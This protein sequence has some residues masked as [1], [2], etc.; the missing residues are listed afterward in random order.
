MVHASQ[1]G[2][3]KSTGSVRLSVFPTCSA[4]R[5]HH[6][7]T[8]THTA[9]WPCTIVLQ[10]GHPWLTASTEYSSWR[11]R[12]QRH[13]PLKALNTSGRFR[14]TVAKPSVSTL[15]S[16]MFAG[17][18]AA[19]VGGLPLPAPVVVEATRTAVPAGENRGRAHAAG[20]APKT[21]RAATSISLRKSQHRT[22]NHTLPAWWL[23]SRLP[24]GQGGPTQH[25]SILYRRERV[26]GGGVAKGPWEKRVV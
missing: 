2:R 12:P 1:H 11:G 24:T 18:S 16:T 5:L 15:H 13:P 4:G 6:T 9:T 3:H 20:A 25:V 19:A 23:E 7:H 22:A 10:G 8:N 14:V 26:P 17:S 21:R